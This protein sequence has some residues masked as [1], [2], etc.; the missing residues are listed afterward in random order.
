MRIDRGRL[1]RT[2]EAMSRIGATPGGGITR[3]A[4]TDEDRQARDLFSTWCREAGYDVRVDDV[5]NIYGWRA[6]QEANAAPVVIGSHLDSVPNGGNFDGVLGVLAGLEVAR[7]LDDH[8][9]RTGRPLVVTCFSNEEGI[10]FEPAMGCSGAL[11]GRYTVD[12]LHDARDAAGA[13]FGDELARIGYLGRS[14][15]RLRSAHAYFELHIEQ[16][17][18]LERADVSV[19]VVT[20]VRGYQWAEVQFRGRQCH[21]GTTPMDERRDA[22]V[23]AS[24]LVVEIRDLARARPGAFATV[25]NLQVETLTHA[26]HAHAH[27]ELSE[28]ALWKGKSMRNVVP[29]TVRLT[30]DMR[31]DDADELTALVDAAGDIVRRIGRE[32]SVESTFM[33][34][35]GLEPISFDPVLT[36]S[37]EDAARICG[38][39][40]VR[41]ASGPGQDAMY[42]RELAPAVMIFVRTRDGRGHFETE[43]ASWDDCEAATNVL[44]RAVRTA[45][46]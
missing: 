46:A 2:W 9:A 3:L 34:T 43:T 39:R 12:Q 19:G 11:V 8:N 7:T 32:E 40:S 33:L 24:R 14:E 31:H 44:L 25:G 42:L 37:V 20:G 27:P 13:R 23:A 41:L 45:L 15:D 17:P 6:G 28:L 30:L 10:R 1:Q 36:T 38:I 16:G 35:S 5:G 26:A 18:I 29:G 4:C 21:A 22:L